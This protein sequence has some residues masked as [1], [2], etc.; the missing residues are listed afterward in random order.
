M[1]KTFVLVSACL[2]SAIA[3]SNHCP[4]A[5]E[6]FVKQGDK[7]ITLTP[8]GW[9][10]TKSWGGKPEFQSEN[11]TLN[12]V[13]WD[14]ERMLPEDNKRVHCIYGNPKFDGSHS[15]GLLQTIGIVERTAVEGKANWRQYGN[16]YFR[17]ESSDVF[18]CLFA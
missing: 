11:V 8:P 7:V 16:S 1:K 12:W 13:M 5:N 18:H 14:S 9:Q 6:I 2:T 17:C 15:G 3:Y 10:W 4:P